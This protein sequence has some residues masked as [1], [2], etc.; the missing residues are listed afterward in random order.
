MFLLLHCPRRKCQGLF[1]FYRQKRQCN[2]IIDCGGGGGGEGGTAM[3]L[4]AD[5]PRS[6]VVIPGD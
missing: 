1:V 4:S 6:V 2:E 3:V 5:C